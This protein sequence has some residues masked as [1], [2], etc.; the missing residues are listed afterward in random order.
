M[1]V[2]NYDIILCF[3]AVVPDGY[4]V[5]YNPQTNKTIMS[6]SS[7]VSCPHTDSAL[8][9]ERLQESLREMRD[10]VEAAGPLEAKL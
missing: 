7:Y 4:G 8:F 2:A 10:V 9:Q 1:P 5:C 3:G 6:V